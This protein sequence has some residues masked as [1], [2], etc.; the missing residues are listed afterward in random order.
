M[1][2]PELVRQK[3]ER[4]ALDLQRLA[5]FRD[6][7]LEQLQSD[8][9]RMAT[10]ERLLERI[11]LRAIDINLHIISETGGDSERPAADLS[12]RETFLLLGSLGVISSNLAEGLS[13]SAGLRNILVHDYNDV[14]RR[15]VH[16]A[17]RLCLGDYAEYV[18]QVDSFLK[19]ASG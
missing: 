14:D 1:L 18:R 19:R 10:V 8:F 12:Y 2:R 11:I 7:T 4:I 15:V 3:C 17:I 5:S 13:R 9:A 16:G 6:D